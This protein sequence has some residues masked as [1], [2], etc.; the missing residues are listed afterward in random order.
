MLVSLKHHHVINNKHFS[1][2]AEQIPWLLLSPKGNQLKSKDFPSKVKEIQVSTKPDLS[3]SV[4]GQILKT[5]V[6]DQRITL[7]LPIITQISF[8]PKFFLYF[9]SLLIRLM[10]L[11]AI[12]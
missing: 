9:F 12:F 3:L 2:K 10:A 5:H 6:F 11:E 1:Q 8:G 4:E 7:D